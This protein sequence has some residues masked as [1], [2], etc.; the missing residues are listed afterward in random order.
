MNFINYGYVEEAH[1]EEISG[2]GSVF[3]Q[4]YFEQISKTLGIELENLVY[5]KDE[6]HYIVMTIKKRSLLAKG[7]LIKVHSFPPSPLF[8][9]HMPCPFCCFR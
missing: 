7:V 4:P 9:S 2:V 5:Y 3:N 1:V 6:T 8:H